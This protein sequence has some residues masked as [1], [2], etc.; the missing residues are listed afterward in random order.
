MAQLA[1]LRTRRTAVALACALVASGGFAAPALAQSSVS[2]PVVQPTPSAKLG[3]LNDALKTLAR[4]PA[5]MGALLR[6]GWDSLAIDDTQSALGFFRR[7]AALQPQNGDVKAGL[8]A[9]SLHLDDPVNAVR[10]FAE[11]EAAGTPMGRYA[12]DRGLALDLVGNNAGAQRLYLQAL[13][14]NADPEIVRRLAL[15][16]AIAGDKNASDATL[17]PLLQRRDLAAY[18]TRA[19][20]LAILGQGEE[21]VSIAQTM[22][23]EQLSSRLAPYLRY[24]PRLTRAQQAAAANLGQFPPAAEI[25]HDSPQIAAFSGTE[26]PRV[27]SATPDSRLVPSGQPLGPT[28]QAAKRGDKREERASRKRSKDQGSM[29]VSYSPLPQPATA[30]PPPPPPSPPIAEAQPSGPRVAAAVQPST[31]QEPENKPA[32]LASREPTPASS[33]ALENKPVLVASL[34]PQAASSQAPES[35]P[36]LVASLDPPPSSA[37]PAPPV[38]EAPR[39]SISIAAPATQQPSLA[40]AFADFSRPPPQSTV[41]PVEAVDLTKIKPAREAA[42][43]E[44]K[45]EPAKAKA[46]PKPPANP[47]RFWAQVATGRDV[48]ALAFDWRRLQKQGGALLAKHDAYTAKWGATRRLLTGPYKTEEEADKAVAALKKKGIDAFEFTS[49]EGQDI[50]PLK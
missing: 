40:E 45:P 10:L 30:P 16:Q 26:P 5:D 41:T 29:Q 4:N 25:G 33:Q 12:G 36:V 7:A 11:A 24:M 50:A 44:P 21:A 47:A 27:A 23:P 46:K 6:A 39:P 32:P 43:A 38:D 3:D 18:R 9:V 35:K 8:A 48:K 15:S 49:D 14:L 34:E 17:L 37:P 22:L 13:A 31:Y 20:A 2:Q 1:D 19:F 28:Q 42:R